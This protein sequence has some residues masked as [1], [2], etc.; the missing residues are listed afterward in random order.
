MS[1]DIR[2]LCIVLAITNFLQATAIYMQYL[3]NKTYKGIKWWLLGFASIA[4]GFILLLLRDFI[5]NVLITIILANTFTILGLIFIYIGSMIFFDKKEN[6]QILYPLFI[7]FLLSYFYFTYINEDIIIRTFIVSVTIAI[8]SFLNAKDLYFKKPHSIST[9]VNFVVVVL[10]IHGVFFVFR[11]VNMVITT[12]IDSLFTPAFV[13]V[14]I[15]LFQLIEG[16]L[17]TFGLIIIVNQRLNSKIIKGKAHLEKLARFDSLSGCYNRRHGYELLNRQIK[18]SQRSQSPFLLAFLDIDHFKIIND[19][20]G[21][22]EGDGVLKKV[23]GLFKT[24]LREI[25][26]ICRMGGDEFL[27]IFPD[28]SIKEAPQIKER[29]SKNLEKLNRKLAKHYKISFSIGFS[30]YQYNHPQTMD[31]LIHVADQKMYKEKRKKIQ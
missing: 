1:I 30:E 19:N 29:L 23:A 24:T 7:A 26:I 28:S 22:G 6:R 25:D 3:T 9:S 27:L 4:I 13:Q 14:A 21:H 17:L 11:A 31:E 2:T 10:L 20:Y 5:P 16:I 8:I 15:F 12:P 18:L